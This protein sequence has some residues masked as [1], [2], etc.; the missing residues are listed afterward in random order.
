MSQQT[1][2]WKNRSIEMLCKTCLY[3][4]PKNEIIGRCR[5]NPPTLKGFIP[6]Y[7]I[8]WCGQHRL[9]EQKLKENDHA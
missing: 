3:Y 7:P 9:N 5:F 2:N 6:V 1:D 8:D 4:V